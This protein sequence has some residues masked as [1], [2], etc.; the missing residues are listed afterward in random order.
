MFLCL[1]YVVDVV[2]QLVDLYLTRFDYLSIIC[3]FYNLLVMPGVLQWSLCS[4]LVYK[5]LSKIKQLMETK[6]CCNTGAERIT[7]DTI[8]AV[9]EAYRLVAD[10]HCFLIEYYGIHIAFNIAMMLCCLI[11][12][13]Y[14]CWKTSE[15]LSST[16]VNY[17]FIMKCLVQLLRLA[18]V[19]Y[20]GDSANGKVSLHISVGLHL[21]RPPP[22]LL[23]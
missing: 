19:A 12:S 18:A 4:H 21:K 2:G 22:F 20:I 13:A 3:M 8:N 17:Y 9:V 6:D 23:S 16:V 1:V 15:V 10:R 7:S 11:T 5:P 14:F